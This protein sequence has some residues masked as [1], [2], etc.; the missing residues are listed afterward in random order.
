M[1]Q[2]RKTEFKERHPEQLREGWT[3]MWRDWTLD[4]Y[5]RQVKSVKKL[6]QDLITTTLCLFSHLQNE[7]NNRIYFTEMRM[8]INLLGHNT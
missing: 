5:D 8:H 2:E 4:E 1:M 7:G 6:G 3:P